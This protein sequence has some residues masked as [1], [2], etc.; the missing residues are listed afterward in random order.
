MIMIAMKS[1]HVLN[2]HLQLILRTI[3][4]FLLV[5]TEGGASG[6]RGSWI[7]GKIGDR[8]WIVDF[9]PSGLWI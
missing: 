1:Y 6:F 7:L 3:S 5:P 2:T 9:L 8:L 4:P